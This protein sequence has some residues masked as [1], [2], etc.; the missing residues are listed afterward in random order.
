MPGDGA[1]VSEIGPGPMPS[2]EAYVHNSSERFSDLYLV[3]GMRRSLGGTRLQEASARHLLEDAESGVLPD[4]VP[5]EAASVHGDGDAG[6]KDLDEGER[7]AEVE[8]AVRASEGI[9]DH[10]ARHADRLVGGSGG[11]QS[12]RFDHRVPAVRDPDLLSG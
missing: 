11:Q 6:G 8:E 10:R 3:E 7:A 1:G 12:R 9:G 2:G 5:T 4:A